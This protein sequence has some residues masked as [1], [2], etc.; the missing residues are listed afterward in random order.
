MQAWAPWQHVTRLAA[1]TT[2]RTHL[3]W[4]SAQAYLNFFCCPVA[5]AV[6]AIDRYAARLNIMLWKNN[7][8]NADY[9]YVYAFGLHTIY[10]LVMHAVALRTPSVADVFWAH[11]QFWITVVVWQS[12]RLMRY[13][14]QSAVDIASYRCQPSQIRRIVAESA[15]AVPCR[16]FSASFSKILIHNVYVPL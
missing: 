3:R 13:T 9:W 14:F 2:T 12:T 8:K 5:E 15:L 1:A 4:A 11:K 16:E 7:T 6:K 10:S